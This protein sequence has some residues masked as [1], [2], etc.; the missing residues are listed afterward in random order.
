MIVL[1]KDNCSLHLKASDKNIIIVDVQ[2]KFD[3]DT[4]INEFTMLL[5]GE[6][7][8]L[9]GCTESIFVE[10]SKLLKG[11]YQILSCF[12]CKYGNFCPLGDQDNEIFCI[13]DF[14]PKCKSDLFFLYTDIDEREKR[15]RTLFDVCKEFQLCSDD[16]YTYK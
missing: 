9:S 7:I 10:L 16:Y 13:N 12:T 2:M 1:R 6:K 11:K 8:Q 14:S 4:D 5:N 3:E 15:R